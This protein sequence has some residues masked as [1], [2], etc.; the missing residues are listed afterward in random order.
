MFWQ[1]TFS[2]L[3]MVKCDIA[4]ILNC[5]SWVAFIITDN[6]VLL[7]ANR[8]IIDF[9]IEPFLCYLILPVWIVVITWKKMEQDSCG[10]SYGDDFKLG[11]RIKKAFNLS[12]LQQ[13]WGIEHLMNKFFFHVL[14]YQFLPARVIPLFFLA[15]DW[16]MFSHSFSCIFCLY[17][18]T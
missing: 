13:I 7:F 14:R 12:M 1:K 10:D 3:L 6:F 15:I 8:A 4:N 16:L 11:A 5:C 18:Q 9:S 17:T 2:H